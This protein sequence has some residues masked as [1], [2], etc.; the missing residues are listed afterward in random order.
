MSLSI[1]RVVRR[2]LLCGAAVLAAAAAAADVAAFVDAVAG[3]DEGAV[4]HVLGK[5]RPVGA[6][7][8]PAARETTKRWAFAPVAAVPVPGE[9]GGNPIDAFVK[10]RLSEAG[11]GMSPRAERATLIRRVYLDMLGL[12]P[13]PEEVAAFVADARPEAYAELV[14]RVLTSPHYGEKWARHWLDVAR[15]GETN[16]FETNTPRRNAWRFRDWVIEA[17]NADMPYDQFIRAQIAGDAT[18]VDV[19]TGFLVGGPMDEVKSPDIVLTKNQRD[20][21]LH[22]MVSTIGSAVLGLTLGCAKCHDHKFDPISM[23]DYYA[24][25]ACLAGVQ[26]GE[27]DVKSEDAEARLAKAEKLEAKA[28]SVRA[29]LLRFAP[30]ADVRPEAKVTRPAVSSKEN[31]DRFPPLRAKAVRLLISETSEIEPCIDELEV[32]AADGTG[33]NVA[34]ASAGGVASASTEFPNVDIHKIAHLNDGLLGNS[35]SWIA[36]EQGKGWARV[37]FAG[38]ETVDCVRWGRDREGNFKDR[39]AVRYSVEAL[40]EDGT[41]QEVASSRDRAGF[42]RDATPLPLQ[43]CF[44]ATEE[45]RAACAALRKEAERLEAEARAA[46]AVPKIYAGRFTQPGPTHMQYRGDPMMERD[47]VT[48]GG[49][50]V[51]LAGLALA[52]DTP[53]QERRVRLAA[54]LTDP[55]N[56]LTARVAVNRLWQHHFGRGIV[57]T[58]GD[59]GAMGTRPVNP[60]LLDWLAGELMRQGWS[61][62]AMHRLILASETYQQSS[63]PVAT[64]LAVDADASLLWRFPPRRLEAEVI[65]DSIL[66]VSGVLDLTMGGPGWDSFE[67]DNS[68][69]HIYVPK[70]QFGPAE[71]RR[72]IYQWKPRK[73]QDVTFGVFDCPDATQATAKRNRSTT[74]LQA[75]ALLNSPFMQEQAE[76]FSARLAKDA[77]EDPAAKVARAF[78]L[79]FGRAPSAEEAAAAG[80]FVAEDGPVNFCRALLNANEFLYL[81]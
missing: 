6:E 38:V 53:E 13:T 39:V 63:A 1:V 44:C 71:F 46:R 47:A 29:G 76:T 48:P 62:K 75:L 24:L 10:E 69:V 51:V 42:V 58:P 12:P 35:N 60:Q 19:A 30:L 32:F 78:A 16:G 17:L 49:A 23:R 43:E 25:R 65:R 4:L 3:V 68:Y 27:R 11:L 50:D 54:W 21:E 70:E 15:F 56:P 7:N 22:D 2:G 77:G 73:E 31:I 36:A 5:G 18:G 34:L 14:E 45:E 33:R 61:M 64:A 20:G 59:F 80:R 41:W 66:A 37:D 8:L 40:K 26:H 52:E 55:R 79:C 57:D 9:G 74:P 28:A 72:M 81:D 67:P